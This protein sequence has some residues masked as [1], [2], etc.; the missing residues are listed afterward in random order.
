MK[1]IA[2]MPISAQICDLGRPRSSYQYHRLERYLLI[3]EIGG[4]VEDTICFQASIELNRVSVDAYTMNV[5][6]AA[7]VLGTIGAVRLQQ[8]DC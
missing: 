2:V 7:N 1:A 4:I 8:N 3:H 5:P 6:V